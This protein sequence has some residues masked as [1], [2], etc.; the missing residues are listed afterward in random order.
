LNR[1][2]CLLA[3]DLWLLDWLARHYRHLSAPRAAQRTAGAVV[4]HDQLVP[5]RTSHAKRHVAAPGRQ[6]PAAQWHAALPV[7][8]PARSGSTTYLSNFVW[9]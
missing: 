2:R 7:S 5:C 3:P 9:L 4:G 8:S 1:D 6:G